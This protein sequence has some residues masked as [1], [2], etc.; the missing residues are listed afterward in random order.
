[1]A[2]DAGG[3]GGGEEAGTASA[4]SSPR[5]RVKFLCSYGGKILPRLPDGHLKYIGGETRVIAIPR[6]INFSGFFF[7]IH[8]FFV[9]YGVKKLY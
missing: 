9:Q 2:N 6:D 5:N 8:L 3:G 4:L 1:M 7:I